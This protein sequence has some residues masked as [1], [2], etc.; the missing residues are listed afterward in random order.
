MHGI[1]AQ[2]KKDAAY[3]TETVSLKLRCL[4]EKL[5]VMPTRNI[6]RKIVETRLKLKT[7]ALGRA[8]KLLLYLRQRFYDRANK[9]HTLLAKMLRDE[10]AHS[11]PYSV[12][13]TAG[14]NM[15]DPKEV[16]KI[17]H[18]IF[19]CLYSLPDTLP[20]DAQMRRELLQYFLTS[21]ALPKLP[22]EAVESLKAKILAEEIGDILPLLPSGKLPGPNGLTLP[23]LTKPFK[24]NSLLHIPDSKTQ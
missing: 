5:T 17:F 2:L 4:E 1:S 22:M 24:A 12:R 13:N 16:A 11:A 23:N 8:E 21:C 3:Q 10:A 19:S 20:T 6:L 15:Y 7:L 14:S 9:L 18:E